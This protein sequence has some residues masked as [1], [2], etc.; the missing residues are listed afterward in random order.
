MGEFVMVIGGLS[1]VFGAF[2][3][4][5]FGDSEDDKDW[6]K[7]VIKIVGGLAVAGI[8]LLMKHYFGI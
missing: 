4:W 8:G 7:P 6:K 1:V 5:D 2:D 3:L